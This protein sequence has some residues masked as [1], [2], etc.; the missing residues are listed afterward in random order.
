MVAI[1]LL[2]F[3]IV[4]IK[5]NIDAYMIMVILVESRKNITLAAFYPLMLVFSVNMHWEG[6][7]GYNAANVLILGIMQFILYKYDMQ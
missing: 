6:W 7:R 4:S 1:L 5:Q 3:L 2:H